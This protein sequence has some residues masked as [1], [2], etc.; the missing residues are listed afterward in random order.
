MIDTLILKIGN[1]KYEKASIL[2]NRIILISFF[3]FIFS[4]FLFQSI[5][6]YYRLIPLILLFIVLIISR[7]YL[8]YNSNGEITFFEDYVLIAFDEKEISINYSDIKK[9]VFIF[10]NTIPLIENGIYPTDGFDNKVRI[11]GNENYEYEIYCDEDKYEQ[12][13]YFVEKHKSK[14]SFSIQRT[15]RNLE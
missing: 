13:R 11:F 9:L 4:F 10:A 8:K 12:I 6:P 7:K 1:P 3:I 15:L 2:F 5:S 14:Y